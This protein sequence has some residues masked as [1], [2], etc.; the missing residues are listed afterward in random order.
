MLDAVEPVVDLVDV[1]L[2]VE[3]GSLPAL[4][5][6]FL[7]ESVHVLDISN[8]AGQAG[9]PKLFVDGASAQLVGEF[10]MMRLRSAR[11]TGHHCWTRPAFALANPRGW[12]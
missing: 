9:P 8:R 5:Y 12:M 3:A 2:S 11:L 10:G 1:P 4:L 7:H 6:V